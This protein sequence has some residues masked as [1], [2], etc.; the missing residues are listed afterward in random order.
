M[1]TIAGTAT[2]RAP[3]RPRSEET[4]QAILDA[5]VELVGTLD[6]RDVTIEKIAGHAKVGKQTIY[7][8]WTGKADLVLEAYTQ[9]SLKRLPPLVASGDAFAD[10]ELDLTRFF[11]FM[12][13]ELVSKGVRSL[14]AEAQ[15]DQEFRQKLYDNVHRVRCEALRRVFRHG[16][17]LGQLREDLDFD[18]LA[19]LIHGAFWYRFLSGT[20]YKAD[21]DYAR[22]I[23]AMLRP[24]IA[25]PAGMVSSGMTQPLPGESP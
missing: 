23:V 5:A 4:Q 15:L 8:W 1:S 11:A 17:A 22:H 20:K 12:A 25:T 3:G 21:A 24:G 9:H 16:I 13:N 6:Y 14:I 7:R 10:L 19:H 18:A 2:K